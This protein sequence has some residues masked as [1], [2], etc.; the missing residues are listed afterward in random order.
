M[1]SPTKSRPY[2]N[3]RKC[4]NSKGVPPPLTPWAARRTSTQGILDGG[5]DCVPAFKENPGRLYEDVRNLFAGAEEF[6]FAGTHR[7]YA[8]TLNKGRGCPERRERWVISGLDFLES[9]SNGREWPSLR[10]VVRRPA[11]GKQAPGSRYNPDARSAALRPR[12]PGCWRQSAATGALGIR[13]T[14]AWIWPLAKTNAGC[15]RTMAR[16]TWR[17]CGRFP[18]PA[19]EGDQPEGGIQGKRLQAGW[20]EDCLLKVLRS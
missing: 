4:W 13:C 18:Q 1:R 7:H 2:L 20:R 12:Q 6:G 17:H 8:A 3:C 10:A 16:K 19:E 15:A 14:G 9:L 5:A 11:A